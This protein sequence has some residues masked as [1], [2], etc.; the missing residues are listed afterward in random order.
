MQPLNVP[1]PDY[2]VKRYL[3]ERAAT[4]ERH[5][6]EPHSREATVVSTSF[7]RRRT[8]STVVPTE[9][10]TRNNIRPT[11]RKRRKSTLTG[12]QSLSIFAIRL[13]HSKII[14]LSSGYV[15]LDIPNNINSLLCR[16]HDTG[17]IPGGTRDQRRP[18]LKSVDRARL[19]GLRLCTNRNAFVWTID[20]IRQIGQVWRPEALVPGSTSRPTP[21][22]CSAPRN[23]TGNEPGLIH[24]GQSEEAVRRQ[25]PWESQDFREECA[26]SA[27]R[28]SGTPRDP[29]TFNKP[30]NVEAMLA[31][32]AGNAK[33]FSRS[34]AHRH[35]RCGRIYQTFR[36]CRTYR[37]LRTAA[38]RRSSHCT[39][40]M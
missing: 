4:Q 16:I 38:A 35:G 39:P 23:V 28:L 10:P 34:I 27:A 36:M 9:D 40:M 30:P 21:R 24:F 33:Q 7:T 13:I 22:E 37:A 6:N 26:R 32:A 15:Y 25:G 20:P 2:E 17:P 5:R 18:A 31:L 1:R 19:P 3:S 12:E 14:T 8:L 29:N 11:N